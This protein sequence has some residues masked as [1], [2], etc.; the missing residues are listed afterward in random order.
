VAD[1]FI[2]WYPDAH[3]RA[4]WL[5]G[6][7]DKPSRRATVTTD[8]YR[9]PA[10]PQRVLVIAAHP[11]DIEFVVAGTTAKWRRA[12]SAVRYV[13][14]T[15]GDAGSRDPRMTRSELA[16]LREAEQRAAAAIVGVEE[17]GFLGYP[18][19]IVEPTLALRRD[20]VR[21]IRRFRPEAVICF[22]PTMVFAGNGYI[23]HPDHRAV[24]QAALDAVAP[25]AAMPLIFPELRLEGLEPH[26]VRTVWVTSGE[27]ANVW[28]DI[29]E[30]IERK[31][32]ALRQHASQFPDGWDPAEM[33]RGWAAESG[34]KVGMRYAE[35]YRRITL[36]DEEE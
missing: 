35:S 21:E 10:A 14:A 23:N 34:E 28:I 5:G 8:E 3:P 12:G 16:R 11:D 24:A 27:Q 22:D 36:V 6:L 31:I 30:T 19:G 29:S 32:E 33:L 17:V 4:V 13:V 20:L 9:E 7:R 25:A 1:S 26:Q 2:L 15:S 18:D